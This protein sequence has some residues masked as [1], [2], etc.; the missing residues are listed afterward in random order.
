MAGSI[1][2]HKVQR[3]K[4]QH[5]FK[6]YPD[7]VDLSTLCEMIEVSQQYARSR[8]QRGIIRCYILPHRRSYMIPKAWVIDFLL[9]QE[10]AK[11]KKLLSRTPRGE[12][13]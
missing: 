1:D 4:Y 6:N 3:A 9:S 2:S 13:L 8:L 5:A 12:L 7:V 11:D 10:Y